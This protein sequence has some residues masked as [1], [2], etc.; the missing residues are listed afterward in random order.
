VS[1]VTFSGAFATEKRQPVLYVTERCVFRRVPGG[2]ELIEV[3]PGIDIDRDIL[4]HMEFRPLIRDPKPMD[5]RIFRPEPMGLAE[6][7]AGIARVED[8][9]SYDADR[10]LLF[11]NFESM[12]VRSAD[13]VAQVREAVEAA[14]RRIGR[15]V[16]VVVDYDACRIDEAAL[17]AWARMVRHM[18]ETHY[19]K[20]TRYTTSAFLRL[21]LGQALE[22]RDV[23]PQVFETETEARAFHGDP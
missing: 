22:R 3:A 16:A 11:L 14:C 15:R 17:D 6:T 19:T 20:V 23:A 18:E 12:H 13:D 2:I 9:V 7:A 10:N 4:A 8:R 1:Q 21:K 5:P